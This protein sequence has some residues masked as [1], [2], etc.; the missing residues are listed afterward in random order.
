M[1]TTFLA[2]TLATTGKKAMDRG[3]DISKQA[4]TPSLIEYARPAIVQPLVLTESRLQYDEVM[5]DLM[6]AAITIVQSYYL[7]AASIMASGEEVNIMRTL[8]RLNPDPSHRGRDIDLEDYDSGLPSF[9]LEDESDRD[10]RER[11]RAEDRYEKDYQ[12]KEDQAHRDSGIKTT[13]KRADE[14]VNLSVGRQIQVQFGDNKNIDVTIKLAARVIPSDVAV[15][16]WSSGQED[17]SVKGRWH[18]F[19]SGEINFKEW[20]FLTDLAESHRKT[21]GKDKTGIYRQQMSKQRA[22]LM[23]AALTGDLSVARASNVHIMSRE[24]ATAVCNNFRGN[25]MDFKTRE[26]FFEE[27]LGLILIVLDS[28]T[29][30]VEFY[31]RTMEEGIG[32]SARELK[33]KGG[34]DAFSNDLI[35]IFTGQQPA[36]R[37]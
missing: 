7:A 20:A 35:K 31:T 10:V 2:Q 30:R 3:L 12:R 28:R 5:P 17:T 36:G 11:H 29:D 26:R 13:V 21:L 8:R 32:L 33:S 19:R 23:Q 18:K 34:S 37:F 14:A 25:L 16:V 22:H 24:T 1:N 27:S 15:N 9:D 6:Q 4:G